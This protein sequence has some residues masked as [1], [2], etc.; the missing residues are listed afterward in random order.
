MESVGHLT[1]WAARLF[2][3][4]LDR[5]LRQHGMSIGQVPVLRILSEEGTLSQKELVRRA[6]IEQPAMVATLNRME[7]V[8]L[9]ARTPDPCD[10]RSSIFALTEMGKHQ[11]E[12]MLELAMLGNQTAL[13]GFSEEERQTLLRMLHRLIDNMTEA[14]PAKLRRRQ[15]DG[16]AVPTPICVASC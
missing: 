6:A 9:V 7:A 12:P 4:S 1:T 16:T 15:D 8:G 14:E 13:R 2:T 3:R 11:L 10:R 5:R